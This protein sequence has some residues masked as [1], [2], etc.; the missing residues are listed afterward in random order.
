M[1]KTNTTNYTLY[2]SKKI[3]KLWMLE[4]VTPFVKPFRSYFSQE[5]GNDFCKVTACG[6]GNYVL[7][8]LADGETEMA[9]NL[10]ISKE[11][12]NLPDFVEF[13][14]VRPCNLAAKYHVNNCP[15]RPQMEAWF[16]ASIKQIVKEYPA[17][18]YIKKIAK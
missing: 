9:I 17:F 7:D 10:R 4:D 3:G 1:N 5:M 18:A 12:V 6:A 14:L 13:E 16:N 8:M 15:G 2:F 11:R